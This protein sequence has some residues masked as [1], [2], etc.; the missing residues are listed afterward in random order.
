MLFNLSPTEQTIFSLVSQTAAQRH[1]D[2]FVIGGWVRDQLLNRSVNKNDIDIVTTGNGIELSQAV[3]ECLSPQP[4]VVNYSRFGVSMFKWR[5]INFEFVGARKESYSPESRKP[6]VKPGSLQDDQLRRDFTI[7]AMAMSLQP[8][9]FG[10]LVD[11]FNGLQDLQT[12]T[13][14]TPTDPGSTFSDDP[15]RMLRAIR[16]AC[17]LDF[18]IEPSTFEGIGHMADRIHIISKERICTELEKIIDTTKPSSGF[19]LLFQAG[20]LQHILPEL[21]ALQGVEV[22]KG[23]G[24]KDNFYHTLKVLDNLCELS[25][26][27]D[28]RWAALF[29]DIGKGPTKRFDETT[30]WTFHNHEMVGA[31]MIPRIFKK[32]GLPLDNRMKYVQKLVAIHQ[33]PVSLTQNGVS[34]SAVRRLL[35]DAGNDIDDLMV[36]C[37]CDMTSRDDLKIKKYRDRYTQLKQRIID[38]E[39]KDQLRNWQPPVSGEMIMQTFGIGPSKEVGIIKNAIREAILDG[40]LNND[41]D[42]ARLFMLKQ[43]EMLGLTPVLS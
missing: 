38:I 28:L 12:K 39:A 5:G 36:L 41:L 22:R 15:L 35:F 18:Q 14:R 25:Q 37:H 19:K 20:L 24:H 1:E 17:Q 32:I 42:S 27:R 40:E 2:A 23:Q 3:A 10:Q 33:R 16:F 11:P 13:I 4:Q 29:H 26:N 8:A 21:A 34:D 30:G 9:D 43:A 7:N 31:A 6:D